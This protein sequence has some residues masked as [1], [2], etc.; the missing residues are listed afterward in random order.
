MLLL[1]GGAAVIG[2]SGCSNEPEECLRECEGDFFYFTDPGLVAPDSSSNAV[3]TLVGATLVEIEDFSSFPGDPKLNYIFSVPGTGRIDINLNYL[4]WTLPVEVGETYTLFLERTHGLVPPAMA[5]MISDDQG[6]RFLAVNDWRPNTDPQV[7]P[8]RYRI[9]A[10]GDTYTDLNGD[11]DLRVFLGGNGCEPR[12]SN[13]TCFLEIT[14]Q[15]LTFV[16]GST[17]TLKLWNR[18][19]GRLGNWVFHVHKAE[20]VV[21]KSNC[22]A[23]LEQQNGMSFFVERDGLR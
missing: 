22:A 4:G 20:K 16:V 14:N 7:S 8:R 5:L 6:M 15:Q 2:L 1:L 3:A 13:T 17:Q 12:V 9:F 19:T 11:G 21:G 10:D 18:E 23:G